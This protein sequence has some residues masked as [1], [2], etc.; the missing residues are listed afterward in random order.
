MKKMFQLVF[1]L[2]LL[3]YFGFAA[4]LYINQ[5]DFI[6][7]PSK[8]VD[9]IG[10]D[11]TYQINDENIKVNVINKDQ[12]QAI[13]YFGGNA[14]AVAYNINTF[15]EIFPSH[16]L[17]LF[18]YRGY[19]GSSGTPTEKNNYSDALAIFDILKKKHKD[20]TIIGRSLGS[21]VATFIASK[22]EIKKLVLIT[23]F[24]SIQNI[25]QKTFPIYP[26][27]LL[28]KDK[29]NSAKIAHLIKTNVLLLI[30]ENDTIIPRKNS[31]NLASKFTKE[32]LTIRVISDTGHN[33]I[34][35]KMA[36]YQALSDFIK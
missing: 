16:T 9:H 4:L 28:L 32:Q 15:S 35:T 8:A 26:M 29:Y 5:R 6:Y 17:Y 20:I 12:E 2:S 25:A 36:Y 21:G 23:P 13:I 30:A 14:E 31:N 24:D 33:T 3:V 1:I 7:F 11:I 10:D 19:G 18:N 27:S 22:R 34:S